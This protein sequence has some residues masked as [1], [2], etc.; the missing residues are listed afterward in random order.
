MH[1]LMAIVKGVMLGAF[2]VMAFT[3]LYQTFPESRYVLV[4]SA[5]T[6]IILLVIT[7]GIISTILNFVHKL[8]FG[9][10]RAVVIGNDINAQRIAEKIIDYPEFGFNLIGFIYNRQPNINY[11]CLSSNAVGRFIDQAYFD[12]PSDL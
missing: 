7:R 8:G 3:F 4:Y 9:N 11:N 6:A 2:E 10:K 5:L 12:R 1:E